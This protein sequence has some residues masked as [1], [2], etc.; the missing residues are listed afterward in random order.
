MII[1]DN[2]KPKGNKNMSFLSITEEKEYSELARRANSNLS[3]TDTELRRLDYLDGKKRSYGSSALNSSGRAK[4][5]KSKSSSDSSSHSHG[6]SIFGSSIFG[7]GSSS[8]S[9][10]S[11]SSDDSSSSWS[12]SSDSGSS[13]DGGGSS[14]DF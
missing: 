6:D 14:S 12:P 4:V 5:S 10:S 8:S 2:P 3:M 13:F 7:S 11:S 1:T 9:S